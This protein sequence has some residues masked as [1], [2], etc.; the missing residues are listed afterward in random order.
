M[1]NKLA[2]SAALLLVW[3]ATAIAAHA[4]VTLLADAFEQGNLDLWTG[5]S[6]GPHNGLIV[7]DPL[8]P[9]NH[10]L[11]FTGVN[12]GGDVFG[13][14][15]VSVDGTFQQLKLSFDFLALPL[16]GVVPPEYGGFAGINADT[17]GMAPFWLAGTYLPEVTVPPPV[18]TLLATD[19]QWH[20]YSIDFTQ[21][22]VAN[23]LTSFFVLLEDWGGLGSI[24]HDIYFDNVKVTAKLGPNVIAQLVPCN[25]PRTGGKWKNHGAYVSAMSKATDAL[26]AGG[27]ITQ[28]E[29]DA[30]VS[31]AAQSNCGK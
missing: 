4:Q 3:F 6:G 19:G 18:K 27:L 7:T 13:A 23:S 11:T 5:H 9:T 15:P 31:A 25:G 10:V 28:E 2:T 20:H 26:L 29:Q 21:V 1:K 16:G 24:P 8:Q 22:A 12:F 14:L 30:Y 17:I